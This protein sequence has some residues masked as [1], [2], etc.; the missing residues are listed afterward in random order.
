MKEFLQRAREF[1]RHEW[2]ELTLSLPSLT[3]TQHLRLLFRRGLW[4]VTSVLTVLAVVLLFDSL[5]YSQHREFGV[6]L[7]IAFVT[8][9]GWALLIGRI[10]GLDHD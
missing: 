5:I 6:F 8:G 9:I 4:T 7:P 1:L 3:S 2:Q 10:G